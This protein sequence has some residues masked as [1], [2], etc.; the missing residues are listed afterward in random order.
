M[1]EKK[2]QRGHRGRSILNFLLLIPNLFKIIS[3]Y[4]EYAKAE[5]HLAIRNIVTLIML[6]VMLACL[7][8]ATW[9]SLLA[10]LFYGL[11]Q[12]QW[13]WYAAAT[14]IVLLNVILL[15]VLMMIINKVKSHLIFA[16]S[17]H[18]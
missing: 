8:M 11:I 15:V 1:T 10:V 17:L 7:L 2:K 13:M 12:L 18:K 9:I 4:I 5:T 16:G 6:S 3:H 14:V